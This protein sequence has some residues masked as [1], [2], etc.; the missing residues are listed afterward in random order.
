LRFRK[1]MNKLVNLL[2]CL[3][4]ASAPLAG[5]LDDETVGGVDVDLP[6]EDP[7]LDENNGTNNGTNNT[8]NNTTGNNN[9]GNTTI[10]N[11]TG[12]TNNTGNNNTGNNNTGNDNTGNDNTGN[13]NT[14]N[15]TG[16][17]TSG[18][19]NT[20]GANNTGGSNNT[21]GANNTGGT[22]NTGGANNTGGT[23]NTG[24]ANNTGNHTGNTTD[25]GNAVSGT[26]SFS[27]TTFD[28]SAH[29]DLT[30]IGGIEIDCDQNLLYGYAWNTVSEEEVFI[31]IEPSNGLVSQLGVFQTIE[32]VSMVSTFKAGEY[33]SIMRDSQGV[34]NIVQVSTTNNYAISVTAIDYSTESHLQ[35][36]GGIEY[37]G[38]NDLLYGYAI[39]SNTDDIMSVSVE[40]SNG[41]VSELGLIISGPAY[42]TALT[43][44]FDGT[45]YYIGIR[46]ANNDRWLGEVSMTS[47]FSVNLLGLANPSNANVL[48]SVSGFE[49][50]STSGLVYGF[51]WDSTNSEELFLV[52]DPST[53]IMTTVGVI[54]GITLT[55]ST[56]TYASGDFYA[57]MSDSSKTQYI[58]HIQ[59]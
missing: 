4:I 42:V 14:G 43:T 26:F 51:G 48:P 40:P 19:N 36:F 50:D 11:N 32:M 9:T 12:G 2:F 5:C 56:S 18:T 27:L 10:G 35:N 44:T 20:G 34:V 58:V 7:F 28:L 30:N 37:D 1:S 59:F 31:S 16:N 46:D 23:N 25:C 38:V 17:N 57:I 3:M 13:N 8:G 53:E 29:P 55:T 52:Y 22:N 45:N 49:V 54:S 41:L 39:D 6:L 21:G 15:N 24:G 33:F 47:T